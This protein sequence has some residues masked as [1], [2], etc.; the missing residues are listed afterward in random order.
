MDTEADMVATDSE[1][2]D[3]PDKK[4]IKFERWVQISTK[5]FS[6]P[7]S[8]CFWVLTS[9]NHGHKQ[10]T[11]LQVD[12]FIW[13]FQVAYNDNIATASNSTNFL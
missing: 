3:D 13:R 2:D 1:D 12:L 7:I 9:E 6:Q 5:G 8:V 10:T 4:R 11:T